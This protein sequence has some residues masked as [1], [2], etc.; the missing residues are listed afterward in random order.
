MPLSSAIIDGVDSLEGRAIVVRLFFTAMLH[1]LKKEQ[2]QHEA[3]EPDYRV[4]DRHNHGNR[5]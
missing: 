4:M 5:N 3:D 2:A 1:R